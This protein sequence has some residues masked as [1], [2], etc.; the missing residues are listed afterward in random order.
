MVRVIERK[1]LGVQDFQIH[2]S[3]S[4]PSGIDLETSK[5]KVN[6]FNGL[7]LDPRFVNISF[8]LPFHKI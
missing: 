1:I 4:S 7:H 6:F 8:L 2:F 5:S 3:S